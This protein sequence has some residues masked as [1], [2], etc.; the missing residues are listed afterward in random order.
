MLRVTLF[1]RNFVDI[2][3]NTRNFSFWKSQYSLPLPCVL[4]DSGAGEAGRRVQ[5]GVDAAESDAQ[6]VRHPPGVQQPGRHRDGPQR[7]HRGDQV[8][9]QTTDGRGVVFMTFISGLYSGCSLVHDKKKKKN[10]SVLH[11]FGKGRL[12]CSFFIANSW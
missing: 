10:A 8:A 3:A 2:K 5:P 9:A 12:H 4:Q 1:R 6:E 11:I 7:L